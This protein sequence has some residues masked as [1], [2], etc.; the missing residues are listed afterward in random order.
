MNMLVI[1]ATEMCKRQEAKP[2]YEDIYAQTI[3]TKTA[4]LEVSFEGHY[5]VPATAYHLSAS[6]LLP[7]SNCS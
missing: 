7:R 3:K 4:V 5:L 2:K 1:H 6:F